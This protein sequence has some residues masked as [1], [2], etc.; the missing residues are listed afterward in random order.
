ME[1]SEKSLRAALNTIKALNPALNPER[2]FRWI[3]KFRRLILGQDLRV[4]RSVN[5]F[6]W[7]PSGAA[8]VA[9]LPLRRRTMRTMY[10]PGAPSAKTQV[11]VVRALQEMNIFR[12][13]PYAAYRNHK[14]GFPIFSKCGII[15]WAFAMTSSSSV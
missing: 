9:A 2:G 5:I 7:P 10:S 15:S 3:G 4:R 11:I 1:F 6:G 14:H 12:L 13:K 8:L